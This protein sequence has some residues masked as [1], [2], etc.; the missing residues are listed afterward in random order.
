MRLARDLLSVVRLSKMIIDYKGF[1]VTNLKFTKPEKKDKKI[2][3]FAYV[4]SDTG[5]KEHVFIRTPLCSI[6]LV[7]PPSELS[8]DV[9]GA[10]PLIRFFESIDNFVIDILYEDKEFFFG[11][12]PFTREHITA[13]LLPTIKKDEQNNPIVHLRLAPGVDVQNQFE[14]EQRLSDIFRSKVGYTEARL[15]VN[16]EGLL[17]TKNTVE[18]SYSA[19]QIKA[20]VIPQLANFSIAAGQDDDDEEAMTFVVPPPPVQ[21]RTHHHVHKPVA[22]TKPVIKPPRPAPVPARPQ[23]VSVPVVS[24]PVPVPVVQVELEPEPEV[25]PTIL[26]TFLATTT[27][28]ADSKSLDVMGEESVRLESQN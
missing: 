25:A 21:H 18:V 24:V 16:L 11:N 2:R 6:K 1:N 12:K 27:E 14:V 9:S 5:D 20:Y 15:V 19:V 4:V 10:N 7:A 3:S 26:E 13:A 22:V 28:G 23:P 17:F 8:V